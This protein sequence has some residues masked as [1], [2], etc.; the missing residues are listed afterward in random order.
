MKLLRLPRPSIVA[1]LCL[2]AVALAVPR[3]EARALHARSLQVAAPV[4]GHRPHRLDH[5]N[6]LYYSVAIA[7]HQVGG[8]EYATSEAAA[9]AVAH[10]HGFEFVARVGNLDH[11]YLVRAPRRS[12]RAPR[13]H[14]HG[15]GEWEAVSLHGRSPVHPEDEEMH[16]L[17]KRD[18]LARHR[19][20]A[21]IEPQVPHRRLH[22]RTTLSTDEAGAIV[23]QLGIHDPGF[24]RQWHLY[25]TQRRQSD[26]N[27]LPAWRLGATG[28]NVTV[29]LVDDGLDFTALDL[30]DKFEPAGSYDFNDHD[31]LPR[32]RLSDDYHGTR[33]A[34]E[35][36]A[37]VNNACG[38]GVALDAK[39]A[40]LRILSGPLSTADEASAYTH[41]DQVNS[42]Y[43]CSFGPSDDGTAVEGPSYLVQS[44]L[45]RA[46]EKG[47][48]GLGSIY[49]F[50]SGNGGQHLDDCNADG[51]ANSNYTLTIG[52]IDRNDTSPWYAENCAAQLAVTYSG[53]SARHD[54]IF[55]TDIGTDQCVDTHSG[56][57]A[58]AP[59]GAA[60]IALVLSERPDLTWRTVQRLI[61]E[62]AV[63]F[64]SSSTGAGTTW[65][66]LPS[67]RQFA[68][69]FGY[70]KLDAERLVLAAR[71]V[72]RNVGPN[73]LLST[74]WV[75][76]DKAITSPPPPPEVPAAGLGSVNST[77]T[78][79]PDMVTA[80]R[81]NANR[82]EYVAVTVEIDHDRR[83]DVLIDLVSPAGVVS[84]LMT[85]RPYDMSDFGFRN[86]TLSTVQHW[87]EAAVGDWTL[88]VSDWT[89][90]DED[91]TFVGW[92]LQVSMEVMP[93][94]P[95]NGTDPVSPVPPLQPTAVPTRAGTAG[96]TDSPSR[97]TGTL[98]PSLS[99]SPRPTS[100]PP[101]PPPS[102]SS[103]LASTASSSSK[104]AST[105]TSAPISTTPT[106]PTDE[107]MGNTTAIALVAGLFAGG[108]AMG[109][110]VKLVRSGRLTNNPLVEWW[111]T[112]NGPRQYEFQELR[113]GGG[114]RVG[115]DDREVLFDGFLDDEDEEDE[116][117]SRRSPSA[118][119]GTV[120]QIEDDEDEDTEQES[121]R[122]LMVE[123]D[124][125][126]FTASGNGQFPDL[127]YLAGV[128]ISFVDKE[129][130]IS[131][132]TTQSAVACVIVCAW[133]SL[134]SVYEDY[135]AVELDLP[136][137]P[138][139]LAFREI[140]PL[141]TV[142]QRIPT[143]F[144]PQLIM[145]DGNG[146]LHPRRFGLAC[147]LGVVS[148]I[149]TLGVG[150]NFLEIR[151][152]GKELTMNHVKERARVELERGGDYFLLCGK[153]PE[154]HVYGAAVLPLDSTTNP[155]FVSVGHRVALETAVALVLACCKFR[156]PEP[157]RLA[158]LKSRALIRK[159]A[160][161]SS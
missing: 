60:I 107:G 147:H 98:A 64:E 34:G 128:D 69:K 24:P 122:A 38:V 161:S 111:H 84:N 21:E 110:L 140:G 43:S 18:Q 59:I 36:A 132:Q 141:M 113:G 62:N 2:L 127:K 8:G 30:K 119:Q 31:P 57:S 71:N 45:A 76:V 159:Q 106:P 25:N 83:G 41:A 10:Q 53:G 138:G 87:D 144:A 109:A 49:V 46:V 135:E 114:S 148:G 146:K 78:V 27:V 143:K 121:L 86:W 82:T 11:H 133:P 154:N 3:A 20:V 12:S 108:A 93:S 51:Y 80:V 6:F 29:A 94:G 118:R 88:V 89:N 142:I 70:G 19:A 117:G 95:T 155:V 63:P 35:V 13:P 102:P 123:A 145:V 74:P 72:S 50:A 100:A 23:E 26:I 77:I 90:P 47:R 58:A 39:V 152:E 126:S 136:Y 73:V 65:A 115:L 15:A 9:R 5:D 131:G 16:I 124:D 4:D 33:C 120:L 149:P 61:I 125:P 92:S 134:K 105:V 130:P 97:P 116:A 153:P 37:A 129:D 99:E 101:S 22:K 48:G 55:T 85:R 139:F 7:P 91:G 160:K 75:R 112:R 81:G 14:A 79:T 56:T 42:I 150:K 96:P 40:G 156:I 67:G 66:K 28:K 32:P 68:H 157:I 104:A 137:I 103:S 52:A 151:G 44:A 158:D 1:L 54:A 17:H